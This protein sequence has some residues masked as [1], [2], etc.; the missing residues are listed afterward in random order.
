MKFAMKTLVAASALVAAGAASAASAT[1]P[2]G[3]SVTDFG[4]T[5]SDLTGSGTL[6]FSSTLIG[7]LNAG[8]LEVSGVAPADATVV[9]TTNNFTKV[10]SIKS[11]SAAAPVTS[12]TGDYT[13]NSLTVTQ[14]A[15]AGGALQQST[16][17]NI[18]TTGGS[19]S[20]T[21]LRVDL[22]EKKVYADLNGGNGVGLKANTYLWDIG[23]ITGP[24]T[25]TL[26]TNIGPEGTIISAANTLTG[27]KINAAA[28][29]IFATSLGL[30]A[31]GRTSLS[32][33]TD[34]G[35][36]QSNISV[37][38]TPAIPEPSTYAM[39]VAGLVGL[40]VVARRRRAA[41]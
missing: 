2:V 34:F 37:K 13:A 39:M 41:K 33:V 8:R 6:T 35:V 38:V 29:E 14:V 7:A 11:A 10:V 36:I 24:T 40:G 31:N 9:K 3:G 12:L 23:T 20:V 17:T 5:L 16:G 22:V 4:Y 26:P 15:T 30:T 18:A 1:L 32:T 19:L 28:F 25:F 27:L 21:N